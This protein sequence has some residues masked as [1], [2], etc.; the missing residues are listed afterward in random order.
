MVICRR[1]NRLTQTADAAEARYR[2]VEPGA[3]KLAREL[4][5]TRRRLT[6]A[7]GT[8][9]QIKEILRRPPKLTKAHKSAR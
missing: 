7:L 1:I 8:L 4:A 2:A 9:S 5:V 6:V 3:K